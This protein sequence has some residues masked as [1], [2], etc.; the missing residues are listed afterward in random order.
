MTAILTDKFKRI[1]AQKILDEVQ[2]STDSNEYYIGIGKSDEY[3]SN[4]TLVDPIRTTREERELRSNL[5]SIKKVSASSFV[6]TR[7]NWSSG[8]I[9][10]GY[11]D[12]V[13]GYGTRSY[14]VLTED[15]ELYICLQ[16]G[17][18]ATGVTN[19][20]TVKPSF[21]TAGVS[22]HQAFETADGYRWKFLY[23]LS[24]TRATDFLS[25]GFVPV[26]RV[27]K[28]S[29]AASAF[30]IQQLNVQ[31]YAVGGQILSMTKVSGGSGY[32]SAPTVHIHGDGTDSASATATVSGGAVVKVELNN[33]SAAMGGGYNVASVTFSGGGGTG[34]EYRPVIGP[35][36]G[37]GFDA[38][39][40]LKS[41]SIMLNTRPDG[42]ESGD[43]VI[44]QDFRQIAVIR[45][46]DYTDSA[47]DGGRYSGTTARAL[48]YLKFGSTINF[49]ND[50]ILRGP[51]AADGSRPRGFVVDVDSS[52]VYYAQNEH[53][54]FKPFIDNTLIDDS[55]GSLSGT[56]DSA[57][58]G[59]V[60]DKYSGE[61][62][63]IENRGRI[64][65]SSSQTEDIK[66]VITV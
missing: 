42:T 45:N 2:S 17:K 5:Q 33:E 61:V 60:I 47:S 25:A 46:V 43:F 31:N 18:S 38:R 22:D 12:N 7:A 29:S 11:D 48:D 50:D 13:V 35:A 14:Y 63:Y 41:S 49:A 27:T 23:P 10:D 36:N 28:D 55:D 37:I 3:P 4:D 1:F 65:R 59:S 39:D 26:E 40:D 52:V 15:N 19:T 56:V 6:A 66:V 53:T 62:L 64:V 58:K 44:D 32:T 57:E 16:Q 34:A 20:S 9:Y 51:A 8:A 21:S 24:A 54:G 30:E